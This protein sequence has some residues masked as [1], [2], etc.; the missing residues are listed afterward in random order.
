MITLN[1]V[2]KDYNDE[3][4]IGPANLEIP[5]GG[6][7]ALVGPNGAGKSTLLTMVGRL[8]DID[9]GTIEVAG[10][11]VSSTKSKDLAKILSILRQENHFI[12]KLTVRQLVGFGRFPYS[13]GRLTKKD[14]EIISTY[15][16]FFGLRELE[17][18]FLDQ[19]S[20]G[21]RQRAYVAMVLCQETDYVLLDEPLNNLDIAHSVQMMQHLQRAAAEFGRTIIVVLHDI[22]FASKY[23]DN[24]CAV[25]DGQICAFGPAE[26]I[27]HAETL[28]EIF[29]TPVQIVDGPDG[30]LACYF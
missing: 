25:K 11:D 3:V 13:H 24:I 8:L 26:E 18:R 12:T 14:E 7:T 30:P 20:G 6:I 19:L 9:E 1:N 16:D 22:N 10:Y 4:R 15:I 23:A 17:N 29:N 21:Q 2:K 27:M 28:S 5:A